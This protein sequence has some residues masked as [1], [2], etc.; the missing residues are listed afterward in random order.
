[1]GDLNAEISELIFVNSRRN[2]KWGFESRCSILGYAWFFIW[3]TFTNWP[4]IFLFLFGMRKARNGIELFISSPWIENTNLKLFKCRIKTNYLVLK[5]KKFIRKFGIKV[6]SSSG[7]FLMVGELRATSTSQT[8]PL[9]WTL[10]LLSNLY[11]VK[12]R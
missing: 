10:N 5:F 2:D 12:M 4:T 9:Y 3:C 1:M 8:R 7:H 6:Y 11:F